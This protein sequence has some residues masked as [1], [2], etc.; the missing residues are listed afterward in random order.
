[1]IIL[2]FSKSILKKLQ[3]RGLIDLPQIPSECAHSA[4]M[5]YIKVKDI[6]TR[7]AL[8]GCL[9][10]T[11]VL[12]VFHYIPLHSSRAGKRYGRFSG[13][14]VWTARESKR[15]LRL[16]MFYDLTAGDVG[17][18]IKTIKKFYHEA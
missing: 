11:G 17:S 2:S 1:M 9:K 14:D 12:S 8:I 18:I 16:P 4:H 3:D 13:K 15:I 7:A 6:K 10:K 5:F